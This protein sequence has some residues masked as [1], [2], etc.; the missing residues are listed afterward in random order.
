[1]L[2]FRWIKS[3]SCKGIGL[4]WTQF[5]PFHICWLV[6]VPPE[7]SW[8]TLERQ[9]PAQVVVSLRSMNVFVVE[10]SFVLSCFSVSMPSFFLLP[11]LCVLV[12][13]YAYTPLGPALSSPPL[14][15]RFVLGYCLTC[16]AKVFI[17]CNADT[18]LQFNVSPG[19]L[20]AEAMRGEVPWVSA[21]AFPDPSRNLEK[22]LRGAANQ[23]RRC[24]ERGETSNFALATGTVTACCFVRLDVNSSGYLVL[25]NRKPKI[26]FFLGK[27]F[28]F[29]LLGC[30]ISW[31][32]RRNWNTC[33]QWWL[34]T[35]RGA[36]YFL[37]CGCESIL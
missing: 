35:G 2:L 16:F 15:W 12:F 10:A 25:V 32:L 20:L 17:F 37:G 23:T 33:N 27:R 14:K 18:K 34:W 11:I 5:C 24:V 3:W 28:F 26:T 4:C 29:F 36:S 9:Q 8:K 1:M 19:S 6:K 22:K 13:S 30:K 7:H 21:F 31:W